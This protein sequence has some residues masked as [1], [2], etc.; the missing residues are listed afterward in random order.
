M[1]S[2]GVPVFYFFYPELPPGTEFAPCIDI[3]LQLRDRVALA[4]NSRSD[5]TL[6]D[7]GDVVTPD[8]RSLYDDDDVHCEDASS[9]PR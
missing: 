4:A 9:T 8:Q 2:A 1:A 5:L 7:G 3:L 6:I